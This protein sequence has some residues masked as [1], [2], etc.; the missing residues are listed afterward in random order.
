MINKWTKSDTKRH[1]G[2][3]SWEYLDKKISLEETIET[4]RKI[5]V[6]L[7]NINNI[8]IENIKLNL[9]L[10]DKKGE[11][12]KAWSEQPNDLDQTLELINNYDLGEHSLDMVSLRIDLGILVHVY[13]SKGEIVRKWL[14]CSETDLGNRPLELTFSNTKERLRT[15]LQS[16]TDVWLPHTWY[17]QPAGRDPDN[18]ELAKLNLPVLDRVVKSLKSGLGIDLKIAQELSQT[19]K[20]ELILADDKIEFKDE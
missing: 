20:E 15:I 12:V 17:G 1:G 9:A 16:Y 7:T 11:I 3:L 13:D 4:I 19:N 5:K 10:K 6:I 14:D 2:T 8:R 18:T